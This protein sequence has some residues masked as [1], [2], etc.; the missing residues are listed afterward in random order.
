M[1]SA[2]RKLVKVGKRSYAVV[3]PKKWVEL[4]E[5]KPSDSIYM[6]LDEDGSIVMAPLRV[7]GGGE[8]RLGMLPHLTISSTNARALTKLILAL[9]SASLRGVVVGSVL[10]R[11]DL[12]LPAELASVEWTGINT[13]IHFKDIR[14]DPKEVLDDMARKVQEVFRLFMNGLEGPSPELW[15]EIHK[16]EQELDV[17]V[18]LVT[19]LTIRK[20]VVEALK[21][22]LDSESLV[23]SLLNVLAAKVFE[24][25]SDCIDRSVH[26]IE[27]FLPLSKDF[28]RLFARVRDLGNEIFEC[29]FYKCPTDDAFELL[30]R[31]TELRMELKEAMATS[32]PPLLPLLAEVDTIVTLLEDLLE[33]ALIKIH[34]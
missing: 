23:E 4:L 3:I 11:E 14:A 10:P 34:K 31:A 15:S 2:I 33:A 1:R 19:R 12:L 17:S 8:V 6:V 30:E 27:E 5:I 28:A 21:K 22:G 16:I 26:R 24:D 20:I 25:I 32:A 9:Y 7:S 13:V 29:Y 18:H